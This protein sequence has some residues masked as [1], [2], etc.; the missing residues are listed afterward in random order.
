MGPPRW[1]NIWVLLANP[2]TQWPRTEWSRVQTPLRPNLGNILELDALG[3]P[4]RNP[5]SEG[6]VYCCPGA[7]LVYVIIPRPHRVQVYKKGN[8]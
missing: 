4:P 5:Q 6:I 3:V 7:Q 8:N 1:R 2:L